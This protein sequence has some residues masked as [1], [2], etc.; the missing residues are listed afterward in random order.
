MISINDDLYIT[1]HANGKI[2][3]RDSKTDLITRELVNNKDQKANLLRISEDKSL[4]Y[5]LFND[6]SLVKINL[7]TFEIVSRNMLG[8]DT[9]KSFVI[10][11]KNE[12]ITCSSKSLVVWTKAHKKIFELSYPNEIIDMMFFN[13]YSKIITFDTEGFYSVWSYNDKYL[14][15]LVLRFKSDKIFIASLIDDSINDLK[16]KISLLSN[17]VILFN[18]SSKVVLIRTSDYEI[19]Q[20]VPCKAFCTLKQ[21]Y[22]VTMNLKGNIVFYR[23]DDEN[24]KVS[25]VKR[26]REDHIDDNI[27]AMT[28]IIENRIVLSS[29]NEI[30]T[31]ITIK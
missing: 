12:V 11:D 5:V 15:R 10:S 14:K 16:S 23:K 25:E 13:S 2:Y 8:E 9:I 7:F 18:A 1:C 28:K 20:D 21:D 24:N 31:V 26:I 29:S 17:D 22:F 6:N 19:I 30:F 27:T 4:L 3:E